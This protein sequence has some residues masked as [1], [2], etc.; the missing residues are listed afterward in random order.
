MNVRY[1]PYFS[2]PN[3]SP[4][5][6]TASAQDS[7]TV[8]LSWGEPGGRHNGIIRE[9]RINITEVESGRTFQQTSATTTL[10]VSGLHP[11]Y[12]YEWTVTAF[13]VREGPYGIISSVTTLEDGRYLILTYN[14][15]GT[16]F[17][18]D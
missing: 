9:Y 16:Q 17:G 7:T 2:G 4:S 1:R 8:L 5:N 3:S 10:V 13:T 11:D 18:G 15:L 14:T 12:S 6:L